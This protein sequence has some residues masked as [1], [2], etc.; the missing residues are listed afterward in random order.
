MNPMLVTSLCLKE[1]ANRINRF[2]KAF[3]RFKKDQPE[4]GIYGGAQS[5]DERH[6]VPRSD[7]E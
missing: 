2:E 7:G 1:T 3:G 4:T 5:Y 6:S